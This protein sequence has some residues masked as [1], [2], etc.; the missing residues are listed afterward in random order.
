MQILY[1]YCMFS[2]MIWGEI[3]TDMFPKNITANSYLLNKTL[4]GLIN[5][6]L[7]KT[8]MYCQVVFPYLCTSNSLAFSLTFYSG[9]YGTSAVL[10][11]TYLHH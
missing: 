9:I 11:P 10:P 4:L 3:S 7:S 1:C 5:S 2:R 6:S 8:L